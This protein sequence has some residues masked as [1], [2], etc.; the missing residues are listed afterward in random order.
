MCNNCFVRKT[1]IS[2]KYVDSNWQHFL[3]IIC[4]FINFNICCVLYAFSTSSTNFAQSIQDF[5]TS[6]KLNNTLYG[7]QKNLTGSFVKNKFSF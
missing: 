4:I 5:A 7:F 6:A 2:F 3:L 1:V